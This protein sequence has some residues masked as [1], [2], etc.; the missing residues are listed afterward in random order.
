[1]EKA[2]TAADIKVLA[3]ETI[4]KDT[5]DLAPLLGRFKGA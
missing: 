1:M 5:K 4:A 3:N 2:A